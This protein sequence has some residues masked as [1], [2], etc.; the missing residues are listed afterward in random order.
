VIFLA[1]FT[2]MICAIVILV[3]EMKNKS[4][5]VKSNLI[6]VWFAAYVSGDKGSSW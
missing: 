1:I 5:K 6:Y 4:R 3:V 2:K